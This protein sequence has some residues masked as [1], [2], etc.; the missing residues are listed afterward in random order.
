MMKL[1][2][3][4]GFVFIFLGIIML[5]TGGFDLKKKKKV[6]DTEV[7]DVN[8]KET[9]RYTWHPW[10]SGAIIVGGIA[11]IIAGGRMGRGDRSG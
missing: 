11:L 5:V 6:L 3:I 4:L 9:R 1:F 10:V 2:R 7:L 8:T